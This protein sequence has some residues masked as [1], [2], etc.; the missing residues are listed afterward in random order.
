MAKYKLDDVLYS[1]GPERGG[2]RLGG[3]FGRFQRTG[4][5]PIGHKLSMGMPSRIGCRLG[6]YCGGE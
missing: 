4:G 3:L 6:T 1:T 2:N 5:K